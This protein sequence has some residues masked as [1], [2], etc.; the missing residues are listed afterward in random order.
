VNFYEILFLERYRLV[1]SDICTPK[2]TFVQFARQLDFFSSLHTGA[3]Y[4]IY[5][6]N[7]FSVGNRPF[8]A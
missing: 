6:Y 7:L 5:T 4:G 2:K 8:P 3:P 1:S